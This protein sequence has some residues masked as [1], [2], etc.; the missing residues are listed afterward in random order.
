MRAVQQPL[1]HSDL[2][3]TQE[4]YLAITDES[5]L[6]VVNRLDKKVKQ[7]PG[8]VRKLDNIYHASIELSLEPPLLDPK[9]PFVKEVPGAPFIMEF[10]SDSVLIESLQVRTS[11]PEAPFRLML[12][13]SDPR[14]MTGNIKNEDMIR[15]DPVT[16]R[17]LSYPTGKALPDANRDGLGK[18]YGA[19]YL[20]SRPLMIS[21][22]PEDEGGGRIIQHK[23]QPVNFTLTLRYQIT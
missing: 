4:V 23:K 22:S 6:D 10:E 8:D 17:V 2:A 5:L 3:T 1:G 21:T 14:K 20:Y 15:M 12:F 7:G 9:R 18:L 11:E 19:I 16:Q 13:E